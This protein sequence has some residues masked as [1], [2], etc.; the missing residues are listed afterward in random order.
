M[1]SQILWPDGVFMTKHPKR[2]QQSSI[3]EEEQKQEA[4]RRA[5][6]VHELMIGNERPVI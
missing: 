6:F 5:K 1:T 2:Q 4:E 3:S